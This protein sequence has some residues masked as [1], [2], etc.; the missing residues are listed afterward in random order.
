MKLTGTQQTAGRQ[1]LAGAPRLRSAAGAGRSLSCSWQAA[2]TSIDTA[3]IAFATKP[4]T[5]MYVDVT[6]HRSRR[7]WEPSP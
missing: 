6:N 4:A 7:L 2:A 5:R 1:A 3:P